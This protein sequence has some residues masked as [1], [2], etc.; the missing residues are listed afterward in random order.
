MSE[1][2]KIPPNYIPL[3]FGYRIN[4]DWIDGNSAFAEAYF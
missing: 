4:D 2:R 1:A 3:A